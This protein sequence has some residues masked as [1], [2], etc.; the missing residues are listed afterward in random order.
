MIKAGDTLT[1]MHDSITHSGN[2]IH[3]ANDKVTVLG[4]ETEPA[5]YSKL[6]PDIWIQEQI[7][8]ILLVGFQGHYQPT[9][10]YENNIGEKV[11]KKGAKKK[12][13]NRKPFKSARLIN[14]IKGVTTHPELQIPAYTFEEDD[15]YVECQRCKILSPDEIINLT[16]QWKN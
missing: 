12:I 7:S 4:V 5:H 13:F 3:N 14:T 11:R 16:K 9:S 6:C 10:F 2:I 8:S 15:S 1:I